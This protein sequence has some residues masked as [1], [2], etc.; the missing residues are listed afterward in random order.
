MTVD[1]RFFPYVFAR[2]SGSDTVKRKSLNGGMSVLFFADQLFL[3]T[4][5]AFRPL[6][7]QVDERGGARGDQLKRAERNTERRAT[8]TYFSSMMI[9]WQ[10][11]MLGGSVLLGSCFRFA[12]WWSPE[13]ARDDIHGCDE[14]FFQRAGASGMG[15]GCLMNYF[16]KGF[17]SRDV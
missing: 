15:K 11:R 13:A 14:G 4:S 1:Q 16:C 10:L 2:P 5:R 7:N 12:L 17:A 9:T 8:R 6:D 3:F